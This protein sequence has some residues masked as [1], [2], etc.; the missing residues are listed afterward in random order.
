M[1]LRTTIT[2]RGVTDGKRAATAASLPYAGVTSGKTTGG[3]GTPRVVAP[4]GNP[5]DRGIQGRA[6]AAGIGQTPSKDAQAVTGKH[7]VGQWKNIRTG[8]LWKQK[9][10]TAT[11]GKGRMW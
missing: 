4:Q 10:R 6:P 11:E 5:T 2:R 7:N 3:R 1:W 8:S 9:R